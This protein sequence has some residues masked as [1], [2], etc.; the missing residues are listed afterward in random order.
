LVLHAEAVP[1]APAEV[2]HRRQR[3]SAPRLL[4]PAWTQSTLDEPQDMIV[5]GNRTVV[6]SAGAVRAYS[7][8]TG[9]EQWSAR[10][11]GLNP[12]MA[13]GA[14]TVI[15]SSATGWVAL[16]RAT[17]VVRWRVPSGETPGAVAIV[18][19]AD[20]PPVAVVAT[21]EGGLAA[22]DL[23]TGVMVWSQRMP[24][25]LRG[26]P[27]A[28]G[29]GVAA[30]WEGD[31][32]RLKVLDAGT[33]ALRWEH[34]IPARAGTPTVAGDTLVVAAGTGG[35]DGRALAFTLSDG[36]V[37][38]DTR[39]GAS[40][41]PQSEPTVDGNDVFVVDELGGV[42]RL[43]FDTGRLRWRRALDE[44]VLIARPVVVGDAVH[45]GVIVT[46]AAREVVTLDRATGRVRARRQ[47]SGVPM[48][49]VRSRDRVL[50]AQRLVTTD[51]IEAYPAAR[52]AA[53]AR[54]RG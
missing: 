52:L 16:E 19:P 53:P 14:D 37:R 51:Q 30:V 3:P 27:V 8:R 18:A 43:D 36:A 49:L 28:A 7:T 4:V 29:D 24:G 6:N 35:R 11:D 13:F 5:D 47:A 31:D 12:W 54:S 41:Q 42:S 32:V 46:D 44:A 22:L 40:F 45:G 38:W 10:L 50:V 23:R 33:G 26:V 25:A 39:V 34:A 2:A 21:D 48:R 1:A 15:V 20:R 9:T 17:G